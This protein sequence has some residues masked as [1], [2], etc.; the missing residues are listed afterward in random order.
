MKRKAYTRIHAA[1]VCVAIILSTSCGKSSVKTVPAVTTIAATRGTAQSATAGTAFA[2]PLALT[3]MS[4]GSPDTGVSVTFTTPSSG[5]SGTFRN[6]TTTETDTTDANGVAT[7]SILTA[8][9]RAGNYAVTAA[10]AGDPAQIRFNLINT[11]LSAPS[12]TATS[13]TKQSAPA[14]TVFGAPLSV[15]VMSNGSPAGGVSV[16]FTAPASGASGT[17]KNRM[18]TETDTTG[19]DGVAISSAFTANKTQGTYAV[20]A[21]AAGDPS[22]AQFHLTNTNASTTSY[23]FYLSGLEAI[24]GSGNFYALAGSVTIDASGNVLAGEQDYNDA[25]GCTS[26]EPNGDTITGGTLTLDTSGQGTL[27]LTTSNSTLGVGG[28]ETLGVQ[29]VNSSHALIIQFD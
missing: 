20:T 22:L 15:T 27:T 19:S 10:A 12:V 11:S 6:G 24:C 28:T 14:G 16:I 23:T 3:V 5:P 18:A 4:N 21:M 1:L 8:N 2:E 7:S 9:K 13:G 29:F 25:N 17:F 26:P